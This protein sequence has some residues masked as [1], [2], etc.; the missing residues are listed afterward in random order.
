M[1][2]GQFTVT[3]SAL[4]VTVARVTSADITPPSRVTDLTVTSVGDTTVNLTWSAPGGDLD[5]GSGQLTF[6]L[7]KFYLYLFNIK[8]I[9][10]SYL[11]LFRLLYI[12]SFV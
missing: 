6:N 12:R 9:S 1:S 8:N 4:T 10:I 2:A 7:L 3:S 5:Q 11:T